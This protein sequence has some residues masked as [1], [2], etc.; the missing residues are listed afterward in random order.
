MNIN[1]LSIKD[2]KCVLG[3]ATHWNLTL[4]SLCYLILKKEPNKKLIV[5]LQQLFKACNWDPANTACDICGKFNFQ[6]DDNGY[7]HRFIDNKYCS[8]CHDCGVPI[9][10]DR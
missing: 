1:D 10:L 8:F 3:I 6:C 9:V 2:E 7:Y 4:A 5:V